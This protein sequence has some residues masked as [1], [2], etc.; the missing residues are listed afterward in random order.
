MDKQ[1]NLVLKKITGGTRVYENHP[2]DEDPAIKTVYISKSA[3]DGETPE[4]LTVTIK[5]KDT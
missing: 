5:S 1:V 2:D 3:F 4:E